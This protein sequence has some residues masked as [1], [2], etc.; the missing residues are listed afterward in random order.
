MA[1]VSVVIV[2]DDEELMNKELRLAFQNAKKN[3]SMCSDEK[4]GTDSL[5]DLSICRNPN[6][7]NRVRFSEPVPTLPVNLSSACRR[8]FDRDVKFSIDIFGA[9]CFVLVDL[10]PVLESRRA[11][12]FSCSLI[13][14]IL[15]LWTNLFV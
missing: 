6:Y 12:M 15:V 1:D 14:L 9:F 4:S 3:A 11:R 5:L 2:K 7:I 8:H 10:K 13:A